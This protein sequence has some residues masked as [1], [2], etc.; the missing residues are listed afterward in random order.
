MV[1]IDMF[2]MLHE[3]KY[4][5]NSYRNYLDFTF[6]KA[7]YSKSTNC[8]EPILNKNNFIDLKKARHPLIDSNTVVPI[9]LSIGKDFYSLLI[10]G[11]NTG[12]K[13]AS[14]KTVGLISCMA[15]SGIHIPCLEGSTIYVFDNIFA[16][17][18]DEQS[19]SDSLSTFSAHILNI[20]EIIKNASS[21]SLILLDELRFWN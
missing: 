4:I 16:D 15:Q 9:D 14:L 2:H 10:T 19:I 1:L 21:N 7:Y 18:G 3:D 13:T 17:I 6:A 20:V 8:V 11:P 5:V 12:G